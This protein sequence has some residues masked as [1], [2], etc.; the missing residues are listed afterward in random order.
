VALR[1]G[2]TCFQEDDAPQLSHE[3]THESRLFQVVNEGH[4]R[5]RSMIFTTNKALKEW[6]RVLRDEDLGLAIIDRVLERGRLIRLDGPSARTLHLKLDEGLTMQN[7]MTRWPFPEPTN[8]S[9]VTAPE[10]RRDQA[11]RRS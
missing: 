10:A 1:K 9:R 8:W 3:F 5:R 2:R 11:R 4:R 6:G 7:R